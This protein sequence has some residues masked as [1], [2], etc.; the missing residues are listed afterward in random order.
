MCM[1]EGEGGGGGYRLEGEKDAR[2]R[3]CK[4]TETAR[5][6]SVLAGIEDTSCKLTA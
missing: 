6:K 4:R 5:H 2:A 3:A 1:C